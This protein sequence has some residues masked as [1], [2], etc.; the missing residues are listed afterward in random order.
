[1]TNG[2]GDSTGSPI[3]RNGTLEWIMGINM[4]NTLELR[5]HSQKTSAKNPDSRPPPLMS[6]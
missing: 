3:Q 1:M 5:E 4:V 2:L 6:A